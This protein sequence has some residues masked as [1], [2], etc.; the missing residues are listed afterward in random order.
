[1]VSRLQYLLGDG[2]RA[3]F[4]TPFAVGC[5]ELHVDA[6][7][8]PEAEVKHKLRQ[9]LLATRRVSTERQGAFPGVAVR[10]TISGKVRSEVLL[11]RA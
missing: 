1:M 3:C 7:R 4:S 9:Q 2:P 8:D 10:A 6:Q 5:E 11:C